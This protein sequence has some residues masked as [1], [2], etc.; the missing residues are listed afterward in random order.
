LPSDQYS[1]PA[2]KHTATTI[3]IAVGVVVGI[4]IVSFIGCMMT[5]RHW[6]AL[7]DRIIQ[8]MGRTG[9]QDREEGIEMKDDLRSTTKTPDTEL[10]SQVS[11]LKNLDAQR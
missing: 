11:P 5:V 9:N 2:A 1:A 6:V 7:R 8:K 4:V 3:Y 10:E